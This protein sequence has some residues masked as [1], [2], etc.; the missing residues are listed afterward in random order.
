MVR[1]TQT[2]SLAAGLLYVRAWMGT[3]INSDLS[4]GDDKDGVGGLTAEDLELGKKAIKFASILSAVG[5]FVGV[6]IT[7]YVFMSVSADTILP[8]NGRY[9]RN[10]LPMQAAMFL[11]LL[12]QFLL[13]RVGKKPTAHHMGKTS[14]GAYYVLAPMMI[15]GVVWGHWIIAKSILVEGGALPG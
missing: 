6:Y 12:M 14:R 11:C 5:L 7:I 8:Y 13:W 4:V 1:H 10:G 3:L 9:G 15:L 2:L